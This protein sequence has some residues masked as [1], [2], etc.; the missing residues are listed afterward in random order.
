M[1]VALLGIDIHTVQLF[2]QNN[3]HGYEN[4]LSAVAQAFLLPICVHKTFNPDTLA[5][6][7]K[8]KTKI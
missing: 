2:E 4:T 1:I 6:A 7:N 5:R 3:I 8:Q